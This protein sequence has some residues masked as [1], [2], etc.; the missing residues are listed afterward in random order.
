MTIPHRP[1]PNLIPEELRQYIGDINPNARLP[2]H[3]V[4]LMLALMAKAL[5]EQ[6]SKPQ[7]GVKVRVETRPD[8]FTLHADIN[9]PEI[10]DDVQAG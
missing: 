10:I 6:L 5:Q 3:R 8:G 9:E 4:A 2:R 1:P 7:F